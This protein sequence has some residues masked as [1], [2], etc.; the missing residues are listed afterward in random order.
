MNVGKTRETI[1]RLRVS[2]AALAV[3]GTAIDIQIGGATVTDPR[4]ED[5]MFSYTD[6]GCKGNFSIQFQALR[7]D[8]VK[9]R[10]HVRKYFAT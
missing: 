4:Q 5:K 6:L 3:L 8:D 9:V 7:T 10:N 1:Q 2:V